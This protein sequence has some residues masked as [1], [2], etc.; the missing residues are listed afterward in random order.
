M[1]RGSESDS[2]TSK[3]SEVDES[4]TLSDSESHESN[5]KG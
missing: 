3:V 4:D 2:E 5:A 1:T